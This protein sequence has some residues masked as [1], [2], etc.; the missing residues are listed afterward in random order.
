MNIRALLPS[1][2]IYSSMWNLRAEKKLPMNNLWILQSDCPFWK[3]YLGLRTC[4]NQWL[5]A[6]PRS[7]SGLRLGLYYVARLSQPPYMLLCTG[8][9]YVWSLRSEATGETATADQHSGR[10]LDPPWASAQPPPPTSWRRIGSWRLNRSLWIGTA[11]QAQMIQTV[12]AINWARNTRIS[13]RPKRVDF[14]LV[15]GH[16]PLSRAQYMP[17][18]QAKGGGAEHAEATERGNR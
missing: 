1:H 12:L 10:A 14:L 17:C 5:M 8:S 6:S 7:E 13:K 9:V 2:V 3:A 16:F 15:A 11:A 4:R 18:H